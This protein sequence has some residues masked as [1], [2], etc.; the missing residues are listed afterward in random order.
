MATYQNSQGQYFNSQA[1]AAAS[2]TLLGTNPST[3]N[4]SASNNVNQ[5]NAPI[6]ASNLGTQVGTFTQ[7]II[8]NQQA[9]QE[10]AAAN[11]VVTPSNSRQ[12]ILDRISS[13]LGVQATQG[14]ETAN[15]FAAEG[16]QAKKDLARQLEDKALAT[17]RAYTK[18]A[19]K[20]RQNTEGKLESGVQIDLSN[21]ERARNSEL[22]DIAIQQKIAQGN[23]QSAYE[24]A[25]AKVKAQFEPIEN[26]LKTLQNLYQLYGDDL[27]ASEKLQAQAKIQERQSALDFARQKELVKYKASI[28][29]SAMGVNPKILATPQFQK[30]QAAQNLKLTLQKAVD[31]VKKYGNKENLNAD[32][33]GLLDSLRV[34]LRSEI[35]T[36]L[37][38]G[39]VVPGEAAAFDAIA[40]QLNQS[41]FI[42]NNKTLGSL[43]SLLSSMDGRINT[44][45]AALLGTYGLSSSAVDTLLGVGGQIT[46]N[47]P[48][49]LGLNTGS[50][51]NN[52]LGI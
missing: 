20:I 11:Q 21:L 26:Q 23:Y 40:G 27:T 37:E 43:N 28:D 46:E 48:L 50:S 3:L 14:Q 31:V 17:D 29:A 5:S 8:G 38:Q 24:I 33:K 6:N 47:D 19:E 22:A 16:V 36:A 52:P 10:Q 25:D 49:G 15:I 9:Q 7:G 4:T 44:Q 32:A 2:N 12:G 41:Y 51:N 1:E 35:S 30:A 42:R 13:L 34:Q 45:K 18:Q 39:V